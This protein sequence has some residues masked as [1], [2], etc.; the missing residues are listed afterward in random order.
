[1]TPPLS[2]C[3]DAPWGLKLALPLSQPINNYFMTLLL[4]LWPFCRVATQFISRTLE[5]QKYLFKIKIGVPMIFAQQQH[6]L[7]QI[8]I[9]LRYFLQKLIENVFRENSTHNFLFLLKLIYQC[10]D[11]MY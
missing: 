1:M 2:P 5:F 11:A 8:K 4:S 7:R 9:S 6:H 10:I 3:L